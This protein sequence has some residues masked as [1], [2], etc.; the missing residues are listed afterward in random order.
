VD[1]EA[2]RR[3]QWREPRE[4]AGV[5]ADRQVRHVSCT[6]RTEAEVDELGLRPK[7][8]VEEHAVGILEHAEDGGVDRTGGRRVGEHPAVAADAQADVF[9]RSGRRNALEVDRLFARDRYRDQRETAR[10]SIASRQ[11]DLASE[12]EATPRYLALETLERAVEDVALGQPAPDGVGGEDHERVRFPKTEEAEAVIEVAVRQHDAGDRRVTPVT[13]MQRSVALDLCTHFGRGVEEKPGVAVGAH[14]NALL[15]A[16]PGRDRARAGSLAVGATAVP[17][18]EAA[19]RGRAQNVN[20]H[21]VQ[22]PETSQPLARAG[23]AARRAVKARRE[24]R[25]RRAQP[26]TPFNS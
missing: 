18:R 10:P 14:R 17:L 15:R 16:R 22:A 2:P 13:R 26:C 4:T 21:V 1:E 19:T 9:L 7:R 24:A 5:A 3:A 20:A 6:L 23:R 11:L 12:I 25:V 8:A